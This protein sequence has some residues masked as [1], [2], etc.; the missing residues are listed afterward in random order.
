MVVSEKPVY[1]CAGPCE[2][3]IFEL[4]RS[5]TTGAQAVGDPRRERRRH[6]D[7]HRRNGRSSGIQPQQASGLPSTLASTL[8]RRITRPVKQRPT[9]GHRLSHRFHRFM[10]A[11]TVECGWLSP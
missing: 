8:M 5:R 6:H 11:F 1:M 3:A 10:A 2:I 4:W 7:Q 9:D